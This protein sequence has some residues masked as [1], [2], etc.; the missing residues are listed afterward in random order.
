[1]GRSHRLQRLARLEELRAKSEAGEDLSAEEMRQVWL[2]MD[3]LVAK[4]CDFV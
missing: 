4:D 2:G 3:A 1:M